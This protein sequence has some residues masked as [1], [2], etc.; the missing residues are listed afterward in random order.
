MFLTGGRASDV[1]VEEQELK[2]PSVVRGGPKTWN[3]SE[4]CTWLAKEPFAAK[5]VLPEGMTGAAIMKLPRARLKPMCGGDADVAKAVFL[6][7]RAASKAAARLDLELRRQL[8]SGNKQVDRAAGFVKSAP[9]NP[10][11][12]AATEAQRAEALARQKMRVDLREKR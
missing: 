4:L 6:A 9:A 5:V 10:K 8:K 11:V 3:A 1:S 7:L 12:A 2:D